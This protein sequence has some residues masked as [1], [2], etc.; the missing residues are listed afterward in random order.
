[1]S[2]GVIKRALI[3][4]TN[5][6]GIVEFAQAL[7]SEFGVE[8]ISTGGTARVLKEAGVKVIPIEACSA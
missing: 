4:V 5:K 2:F 6:T 8:I 7:E 3:S 1:M